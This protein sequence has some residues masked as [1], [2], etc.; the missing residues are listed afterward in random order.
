[1]EM[2]T[3]V[4]GIQCDAARGQVGCV[5]SHYV[6]LAADSANCV[7]RIPRGRG[8]FELASM[9]AVHCRH[10]DDRMPKTAAGCSEKQT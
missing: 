9:A 1:M 3:M 5:V 4:E 7:M 2:L 10:A 6:G 8:H